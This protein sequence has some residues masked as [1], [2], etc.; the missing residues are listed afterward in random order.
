[1]R[2]Y[3]TDFSIFPQSIEGCILTGASSTASGSSFFDRL[4]ARLNQGKAW[5]SDEV[6]GLAGRDLDDASL[7]MLETELLLADVGVDASTKILDMLR[8]HPGNSG[9]SIRDRLR[10][11]IVEC[12]QPVDAALM[13]K[14]ANKP[15]VILMVGVNGTGKTTSIGKLARQFTGDGLKVVLA[16]GDTF[17]AAAVEQLE[18]WGNRTG[19]PVVKQAEGADPAAVVHDAFE[20]ARARA[21]DVLIADT[22]G[23]LHTAAGL[24]DELKKIK[25]VLNR[26]DPDAPH[27]TLLV[28]DATQG[29]NALAQACEFHQQLGLSGLIVTKLDGSAKGGIVIAIALK[30]GLP[31]RFL[32]VGEAAEDFAAFRAEDYAAALIDGA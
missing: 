11:V 14:A 1:L 31:I 23:R 10:S 19:A 17:R 27:E 24:M 6:F 8:K 4:R 25:R 30:L 32:A 28:V 7:E 20:S 3:E 5:L 26:L 2:G 9:D 15:F 18:A 22:A 21:A 13:P 12:L 29:Q 16:A